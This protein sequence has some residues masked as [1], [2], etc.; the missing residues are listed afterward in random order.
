MKGITQVM[1]DYNF[2]TIIDASDDDDTLYPVLS[3]PD[4]IYPVETTQEDGQVTHFTAARALVQQSSTGGLTTVIRLPSDIKWDVLITD[5]RVIV[6]CTKYDKG[7]RWTGIG[8][9]A[10]FALAAN[11]VSMARAAHR[12]KGKVLVAQVRYPWIATVGGSPREGWRSAENL[13]FKVDAEPGGQGHRHLYL[14]LVLPRQ[15]DAPSIAHEIGTRCARYRLA[16]DTSMEDKA[17]S[18]FQALA[19]GPK[20]TPVASQ[21]GK[22]SWSWY[23]MPTSYRVNSVTAK[24]I[25]RRPEPEIGSV[26]RGADEAGV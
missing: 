7:G 24:P 2:F 22:P 13:R 15:L 19:S 6:Y 17:R 21:P 14:T 18:T 10:I 8:A 26:G 1:P 9:G 5:T 25:P 12:R 16:N 23:E 3:T 20:K 4:D 11:A